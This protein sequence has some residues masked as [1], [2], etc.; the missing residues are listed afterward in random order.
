MTAHRNEGERWFEALTEMAPVGLFRTDAAGRYLY[1]NR[2][3][4]AMAGLSAQ[5]ARG[6]GW[7]AALVP[8]DRARVAAAWQEATLH[9]RSFQAEFRLRAAGKAAT[10]VQ[11]VAT[12]LSTA[13][14][15]LNGYVG[16]LT[17]GPALRRAGEGGQAGEEQL[18][19]IIAQM[20]VILDAFDANGILCAWNQE[21][22]RV[23]GYTAEELVGNP[24]AMEILYPDADYRNAMMAAWKERGDDYY[25]WE[26]DLTAKDGTVKTIAWSNISSRVPIP[27]WSTWGVGVETTA[28]RQAERALQER[29]KELS[30]L[31]ALSQLIAR[32][33]GT[34]ELLFQEAA[35]LLPGAFQ[36][37][38]ATSVRIVFPD[39]IFQSV[40]FQETP[41]RLSSAIILQH[42]EVGHVEVFVDASGGSPETKPFLPEEGQLLDE[43][44]SR[45][46]EAVEHARAR[47]DEALLQE[48]GAKTQ[49][50]ERFAHTISHDLRTP[51][52]IIG[53]FARRVQVLLARGELAKAAEHLDRVMA[54]ARQMEQRLLDLLELARQGH[55]V[56]PAVPV[57]F[58]DLVHEVVTA[59][60][61]R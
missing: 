42:E 11:A 10:R 55:I 35:A 1:V 60:S 49:E 36:E 45:L 48:L 59:L 51:L 33:A 26:W 39:R 9:G 12:P 24:Q 37:P 57:P 13:A 61:D 53:G 14:G 52:T 22:E 5:E 46:A 18:R 56:R 6:D 16:S 32:R 20:P 47:H 21:G 29:V 27:G 2:R 7:L 34:L 43:V 23:T 58:A 3:W 28:R 40:P 15:G 54:M 38:G 8:E 44:A 17:G 19:A 50:L 31:Y 30:C 25:D 4:C 41:W